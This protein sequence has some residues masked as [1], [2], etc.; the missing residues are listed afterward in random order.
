MS[1]RAS[2][3]SWV[4]TNDTSQLPAAATVSCDSALPLHGVVIIISLHSIG[5]LPSVTQAN[6]TTCYICSWEAKYSNI[7]GYCDLQNDI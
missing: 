2:R 3:S 1:S 7:P 4:E 6:S 5:N